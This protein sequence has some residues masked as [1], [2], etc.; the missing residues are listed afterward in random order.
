[1]PWHIAKVSG[2]F[3]VLDT[4][5]KPYGKHKTRKEAEAQMRALYA[6]EKRG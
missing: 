3:V 2:Q 5:G 6:S 1:M 4:K